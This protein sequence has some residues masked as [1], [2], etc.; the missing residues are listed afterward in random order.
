MQLSAVILLVLTFKSSN[1]LAGAYGLAVTG[2]MVITSLLA[3]VVAAKIW[4]WGWY[5]A[6]LLFSFFLVFESIFLWANIQKIPDGVGS[7][8]WRA[9]YSLR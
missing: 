6:A 8:W 2:D 1:N 4:G 5:R 3:V 9:W 7:R